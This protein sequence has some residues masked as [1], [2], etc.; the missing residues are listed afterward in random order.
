VNERRPNL[1][2]RAPDAG[3]VIVIAWHSTIYSQT[4]IA[5]TTNQTLDVRPPEN[6]ELGDHTVTWY[7][8][9]LDTNQK[10]AGTQIPFEVASTAFA[11]GQGASPLVVILG[12]IAVLSS[13]AALALFFR[14][15]KMKA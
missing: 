7:A 1:S 10:S 15:R 4:L 6:L 11:S 9:N 14:N 8:Q 13:L 2:L 12:S 5:D 3:N